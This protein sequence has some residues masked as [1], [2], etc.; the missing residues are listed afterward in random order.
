MVKSRRSL[1]RVCSVPG[2]K[3]SILTALMV[4][5][6]G[7]AR[8]TSR[9]D[10][11]KS[12]IL[13]GAP[14]GEI[15]V[16]LRNSGEEAYREDV[17]GDHIRVIRRLAKTGA[18]SYK[19]QN[20]EGVT[21]SNKRADLQEILDHYFID[22]MN[23]LCILTQEMAKKFLANSSEEEK[24]RFFLKGTNL[25]SLKEDVNHLKERSTSIANG[26][27]DIKA[28]RDDARR[29]R[30]GLQQRY[31][32]IQANQSLEQSIEDLKKQLAWSFV[33]ET[34]KVRICFVCLRLTCDSWDSYLPR[35]AFAGCKRQSPG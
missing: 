16:Y 35:D 7:K 18:G 11:A 20:S 31:D 22:V 5:L 19:I 13:D 26:L 33:E 4:A 34:E 25:E 2:G 15:T 8:A 1:N 21:I 10:S 14:W 28:S 27:P 23:P 29:K 9:G 3:S 12:V 6:G 24:Y 32:Q 30:D 17:Y